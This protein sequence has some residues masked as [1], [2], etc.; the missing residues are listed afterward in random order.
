M[1]VTA[2]RLARAGYCHANVTDAMLVGGGAAVTGW[3]VWETPGVLLEGEFH[4][5]WSSPAGELVDVTPKPD[6]EARILFVRDNSVP[7][8]FSE[9]VKNRRLY[10]V[11]NAQTRKMKLLNGRI[12]ELQARY[13]KADGYEVPADEMLAVYREL[14]LA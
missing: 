9:P 6:G 1:Q 14:G 8:S 10:L 12:E 5:V 13:W 7:W 3:T 4:V 11:D 2:P